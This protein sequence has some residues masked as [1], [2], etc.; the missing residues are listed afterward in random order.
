LRRDAARVVAHRARLRQIVQVNF[1]R[2][3]R[4]LNVVRRARRLRLDLVAQHPLDDVQAVSIEQQAD[5][6]HRRKDADDEKN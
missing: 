1:A 5:E 2:V 3:Q 6:Q 4:G